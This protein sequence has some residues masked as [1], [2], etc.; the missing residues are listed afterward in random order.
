MFPIGVRTNMRKY[1]PIETKK[2]N[3]DIVGIGVALDN[4]KDRLAKI[5]LTLK[6]ISLLP[7]SNKEI[8]TL[9]ERIGC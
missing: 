1:G 7:E 3:S 6:G 5:N 9:E 4:L 2:F 8:R